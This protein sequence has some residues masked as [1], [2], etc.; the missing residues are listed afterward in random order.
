MLGLEIKYMHIF[1][2][3][4]SLRSW[5]AFFYMGLAKCLSSLDGQKKKKKKNQIRIMILSSSNKLENI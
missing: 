3:L 2:G 4:F 5:F 1:N